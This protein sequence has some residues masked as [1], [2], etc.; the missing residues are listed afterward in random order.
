MR[1]IVVD[2]ITKNQS[3]DLDDIISK[4]ECIHAVLSFFDTCDF[5]D[6]KVSLLSFV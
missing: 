2:P 3:V 6:G 4:A 5:R 1:L